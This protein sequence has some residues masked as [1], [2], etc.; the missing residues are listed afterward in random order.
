[1]MIIK[2]KHFF[3]L[4][5]PWAGHSPGTSEFPTQ[6]WLGALWLGD[7]LFSFICAWTNG[8]INNRDAEDFSRHRA[9]LDVTVFF[10]PNIN[11]KLF[12]NV[13]VYRQHQVL[14]FHISLRWETSQEQQQPCFFKMCFF[15][16]ANGHSATLVT[17][18]WW[19]YVTSKIFTNISL[20]N[21]L[22][23]Y[24]TKPV[25]KQITTC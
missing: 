12:Y 3:A 21:S 16:L 22:M 15:L 20:G 23:L 8:W 4:L 1:M 24:N 6:R 13:W 2:W 11:R 25:H 10:R 14:V 9:H 5:T 7:L 19:R 17:P 18:S